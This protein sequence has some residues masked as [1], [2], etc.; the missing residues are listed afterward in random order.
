MVRRS[1]HR[2]TCR[3]GITLIE[4]VVSLS[5]ITVLLLALSGTVMIATRALPTE[6]E[7]GVTDRNTHD[8]IN[9]LRTDIAYAS[10]IR[11]QPSGSSARLTLD[12]IP[13]GVMGEGSVILYEYD[14]ST[15]TLT[16]RVDGHDPQILSTRMSRFEIKVTHDSAMVRF[17]TVRIQVDDTI[18]RIFEVFAPTPYRPTFTT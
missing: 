6:T 14:S 15:D 1:T 16:R 10:A 3:R 9:L 7:L 13:T 12:I 17:L 18:Q 4:A 5:I 8:L 2:T 11:Y